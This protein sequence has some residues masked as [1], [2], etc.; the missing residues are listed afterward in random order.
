MITPNPGWKRALAMVLMLAMTPVP[1]ALAGEHGAK[2]EAKPEAKHDS[3]GGEHGGG[4]DKEKEKK[5]D[6]DYV[7]LPRLRLAVRDEP[8][9]AFGM[10]ELEVWLSAEDKSTLG[11]LDGQKQKITN[12]IKAKFLT[13]T[14]GDFTDPKAGVER[15]KTLVH[16]LTKQCCG[17]EVSDVLVM[18]MTL[19]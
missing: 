2:P 3:G 15:V 7:A 13:Q 19:R 17:E 5:K 9:R 11:R 1:L 4:K 10:L 8:V 6:M 14:Y 16:D 12:A 18:A